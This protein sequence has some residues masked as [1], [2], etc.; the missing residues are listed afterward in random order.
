MAQGTPLVKG[1]ERQLQVDASPD[2]VSIRNVCRKAA[3]PE[4]NQNGC[5]RVLIERLR[6][7]TL[8]R[9]AASARRNVG[10]IL[11]MIGRPFGKVFFPRQTDARPSNAKRF[12]FR[13]G[14]S[15]GFPLYG[16]AGPQGPQAFI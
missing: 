5:T 10:P 8:P 2:S 13:R 1:P 6:D 16:Q 11:A 9:A 14:L 7:V 4:P 12:A 3:R 15:G